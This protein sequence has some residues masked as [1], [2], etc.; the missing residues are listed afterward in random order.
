MLQ[1]KKVHFG[2]TE[3]GRTD[4]K[5]YRPVD[6]SRIYVNIDTYKCG[7]KSTPIYIVNVHGDHF[8]YLTSGGCNAYKRTERGFQV[9]VTFADEATRLLPEL[10]LTPQKAIRHFQIIKCPALA[11]RPQAERPSILGRSPKYI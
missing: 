9:N 11:F 8:I 5:K 10:K 4:W 2:Q 7:F 3:P 6:I 1:G